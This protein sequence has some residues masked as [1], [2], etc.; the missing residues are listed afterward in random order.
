M[1]ERITLGGLEKI[2]GTNAWRVAYD[3]TD[4]E[5]NKAPTVYRKVREFEAP[6]AILPT[7]SRPPAPRL[8]PSSSHSPR[9][10]ST[11]SASGL[12]QPTSQIKVVEY[13]L[14]EFEEALRAQKPA[15]TT[16]T[17]AEACA[18]HGGHARRR[19]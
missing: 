19:A 14:D 11:R 2:G 4:A 1:T 15:T 12:V 18:G 17:L 10:A 5:G 13:S 9:S 7:L 3:V 8:R 16:T 6:T